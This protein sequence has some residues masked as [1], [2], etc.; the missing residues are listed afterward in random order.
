[1]SKLVKMPSENQDTLKVEDANAK[2]ED[3]NANS[4]NVF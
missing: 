4:W 3:G 2:V 1:M